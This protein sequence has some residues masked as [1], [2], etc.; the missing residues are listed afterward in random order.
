[1]SLLEFGIGCTWFW[2]HARAQIKQVHH[3]ILLTIKCLD[4]TLW[5]NLSISWFLFIDMNYINFLIK[6]LSTFNQW[7][8]DLFIKQFWIFSSLFGRIL[9]SGIKKSSTHFV[10]VKFKIQTS[11]DDQSAVTSS[12]KKILKE[13]LLSEIVNTVHSWWN[14]T[15]LF[16]RHFL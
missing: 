9:K 4:L 2:G 7:A 15:I 14:P 8:T 1:M 12:P 10:K 3:F 13:L 11:K 6:Y 5:F 16:L